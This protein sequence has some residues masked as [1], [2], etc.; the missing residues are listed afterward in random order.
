[1]VV[2][3]QVL[4]H[5]LHL[6]ELREL[7]G[8]SD[9]PVVLE[10]LAQPEPLVLVSQELPDHKAHLEAKGQPV[11]LGH[12]G[13]LGMQVLRVLQGLKGQ[14]A[15]RVYKEIQGLM[16]LRELLGLKVLLVHQV[17][18]EVREQRDRLEQEP[19][20]LKD[21]VVVR[22]V[23]VLQGPWGRRERVYQ[24]GEQLDRPW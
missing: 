20:D 12:K 5:H 14:Q 11:Q 18:L 21:Q 2:S 16:E 9:Q 22:A 19:L 7:P 6:M 15:L 24:T 23:Q 3:K 8:L 10:L 13:L 4:Y 1:M 17:Q